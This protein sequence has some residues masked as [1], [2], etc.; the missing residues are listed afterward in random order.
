MDWQ[1]VRSEL[2][3]LRVERKPK[4]SQTRLGKEA[5]IAKSTI[6]RIENVDGEPDHVPDLDT[7]ERWVLATGGKLSAFFERV[8]GSVV[9]AESAHKGTT[10]NTTSAPGGRDDEDRTVSADRRALDELRA[11]FLRVGE[12]FTDAATPTHSQ[13]SRSTASARPVKST[14]R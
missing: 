14:R 1:R 12:V 10:A 8:E 2:T 7:I 3:K 6:N 11:V 13:K 9:G 4:L 5:G